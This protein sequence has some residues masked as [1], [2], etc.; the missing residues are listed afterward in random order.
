MLTLRYLQ[1]TEKCFGCLCNEK[2]EVARG[3]SDERKRKRLPSFFLP[4]R[5]LPPFTVGDSSSSMRRQ[6]IPDTEGEGKGWNSTTLLSSHSHIRQIFENSIIF[7]SGQNDG[8]F[9]P[10]EGGKCRLMSPHLEKERETE[11]REGASDGRRHS[12]S[13]PREQKIVRRRLKAFS[14]LKE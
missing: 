8:E 2:E 12:L 7:V 3:V 9:H 11:R 13:F 1:E 6:M 14:F 4:L 10:S 5:P